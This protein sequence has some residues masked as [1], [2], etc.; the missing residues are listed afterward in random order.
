MKPGTSRP[1]RL[2]LRDSDKPR[3]HS[4][5]PSLSAT[6]SPTLPPHP[7]LINGAPPTSKLV[8]PHPPSAGAH[9]PPVPARPLAK[10]GNRRCLG[11]TGVPRAARN[12]GCS[13]L[14]AATTWSAKVKKLSARYA[15]SQQA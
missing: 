1:S 12:G 9:P 15:L 10:R 14:D 5:P 2:R 11:C 13:Q 4:P 7:S 3:P 6:P 8:Q